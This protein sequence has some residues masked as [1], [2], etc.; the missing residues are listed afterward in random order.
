MDFSPGWEPPFSVPAEGGRAPGVKKGRFITRLGSGFL[1]FEETDGLLIM[2]PHAA[3]ERILFEKLSSEGRASL[4]QAV[5]LQVQL[6]PSLSRRAEEVKGELESLGF[7]F[8]TGPGAMVLES[9]PGDRPHGSGGDPMDMLRA[10]VAAIEDGLPPEFTRSGIPGDSCR[11]AV[12]IT[13]TLA[14]EEAEA[15]LEDLFRC[16]E[17]ALCPHGRPTFVRLLGRDLAKLFARSGK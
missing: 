2:D 8:K 15:L 4:P 6:P 11:A 7:R 14:P 16:E 9:V 10:A 13:D 3:H 17:P 1:L 12:K 5:P